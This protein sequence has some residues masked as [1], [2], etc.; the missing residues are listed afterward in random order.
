MGTTKRVEKVYFE[1]QDAWIEQ[2]ATTQIRLALS[3]KITNCHVSINKTSQ[4]IICSASKN[5]FLFNVM[6]DDGGDEGKL[7]SFINFCE[8]TIFEVL[9]V[10]L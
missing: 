9:K 8:D 4:S 1:V 5:N 10:Y 7:E 2:W 3:F 6:Q